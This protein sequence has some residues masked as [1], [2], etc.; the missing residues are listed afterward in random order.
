MGKVKGQTYGTLADDMISST[1]C[2]VCFM[3]KDENRIFLRPKYIQL[4]SGFHK[5]RPTARKEGR[6]RMFVP[7]VKIIITP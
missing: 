2:A 5:V 6:G 7:L 4:H 3:C 1:P